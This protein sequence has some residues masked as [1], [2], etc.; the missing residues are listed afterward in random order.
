M[1]RRAWLV[2]LVL[3]VVVA[4]GIMAL[5]KLSETEESRRAAL[6][7]QVR[8]ALDGLRAALAARG[9]QTWIVSTRRTPEQQQAKL[10]AGVSGTKNSWHLLGR[11]VDL[12]VGIKNAAGKVVPDSN[13]KNEA[14]YRIMQ[15]TAKLF[16]FRGIPNGSPFTADGKKAYITNP[17]GS[18]IWDVFHLE[19]TDGMTFA[20]AQAADARKV[21]A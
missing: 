11:G 19:F 14:D 8:A 20:Q 1:S 16:G 13:G 6:L 17:S 12:N 18:K 4:G 10:D 3:V 5:R 7:P 21:T 9:I 2:V 15:E